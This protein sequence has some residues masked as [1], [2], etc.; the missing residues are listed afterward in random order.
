LPDVV[1]LPQLFRKNG[2]FTARLGKVFHGRKGTDDPKA[3]DTILVSMACRR[4]WR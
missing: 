4:G 2:Y 1:T 3:W